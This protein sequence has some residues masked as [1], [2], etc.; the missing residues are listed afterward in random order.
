[1]SNDIDYYR[2]RA[3]VERDNAKRATKTIAARIH[4]ELANAYFNRIAELEQIGTE[5]LS[6]DAVAQAM[7]DVS[8]FG[9]SL[10]RQEVES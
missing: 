9:L 6:G 3:E 1:M 2:C 5:P 4:R 10:N 8:R 7:D